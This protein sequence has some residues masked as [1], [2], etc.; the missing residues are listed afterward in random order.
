MKAYIVTWSSKGNVSDHKSKL[1]KAIS[2]AEAQNKF[3]EYLQRKPMFTHLWN[4]TFQFE[5]VEL[6][7]E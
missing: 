3:W 2:L 6:D 4:L 1:I 7:D 5:E